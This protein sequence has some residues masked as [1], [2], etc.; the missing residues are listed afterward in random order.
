[1]QRSDMRY[2]P[3]EGTTRIGHDEIADATARENAGLT[4]H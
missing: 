2:T 1:M 4:W 3:V